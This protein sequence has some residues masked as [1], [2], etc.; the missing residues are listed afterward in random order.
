MAMSLEGVPHT[1]PALPEGVTVRPVR[2]DELPTFHAVLEESFRDSDHRST[3]FETWR[4]R[5]AAETSVSWDEWFVGEVDGRIVGALQSYDGGAEDDEGWVRYLGV[6]RAYRKRGVGEALLRRALAT[7][8]AKGRSRAGLGVDLEN[9]TKAARL[10]RAVGMHPMYE[11]NIY[12]RMIAAA[13]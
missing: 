3:D 6:L 11:A 8:A 5:V 10:Y 7:Y 12:Q 1:A 2:E 9:P 4:A 13:G